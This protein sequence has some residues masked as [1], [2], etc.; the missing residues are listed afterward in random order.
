MTATC[1][2]TITDCQEKRLYAPLLPPGR[3]PLTCIAAVTHPLLAAS[4]GRPVLSSGEGSM[5]RQSAARKR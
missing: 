4:G 5:P 3:R 2:Q 1:N